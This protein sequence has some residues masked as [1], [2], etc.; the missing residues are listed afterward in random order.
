M[1][2]NLAV[3]FPTDFSTLLSLKNDL[4]TYK[5]CLITRKT[6]LLESFQRTL[7]SLF[8]TALWQK[9]KVQTFDWV[10]DYVKNYFKRVSRLLYKLI[11]TLETG[12]VK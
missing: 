4:A 8:T 3:L 7:W 5:K 6:R 11:V 10:M 9:S 2:K 1:V 12:N